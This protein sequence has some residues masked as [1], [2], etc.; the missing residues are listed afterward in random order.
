LIAVSFIFGPLRSVSMSFRVLVGVV[1]GLVF[2]Q[3]Q[4]FFGYASLV[5]N[6][7]PLVAIV[8]PVSLCL[9]AGLIMMSRV[10]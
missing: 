9:V 6:V 2:Q 1:V 4:D 7:D 8:I 3:A 10:R 5:F